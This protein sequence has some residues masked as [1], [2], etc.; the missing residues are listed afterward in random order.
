MDMLTAERNRLYQADAAV[1]G[2]IKEHI[3]WLEQEAEDIKKELNKIVHDNPEWKEKS[4]IIRSFKGAG[5]NMAVTILADFPELGKLNRKQTAALS[6][7]APF[8]RDS[9]TLRGRRTIWGGRDTVRSRYLHGYLCGDQ[10][11]PLYE[12][13]L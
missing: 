4:D 6:G 5:P 11:Q 2:R 9:G 7:V 1:K 12:G 10:I 3:T 8:N 13:F